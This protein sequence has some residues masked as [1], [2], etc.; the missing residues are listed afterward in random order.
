MTGSGVFV[1]PAGGGGSNS[2]TTGGGTWETWDNGT[3]TGSGTYWVTGLVRWHPAP[4]ADPNLPFIDNIGN[5][6]EW[7]AGLAV[8][9]IEYSDGDKGSLVVNCRFPASPPTIP[10]GISSTKGFVHFFDLQTP[11]IPPPFVD[12]NRTL[13]HVRQ[14]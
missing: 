9:R 5:P 1:A 6:A 3:V 14:W 11:P 10:E 12:A 7:S 13:F 8:L 4:G 2:S